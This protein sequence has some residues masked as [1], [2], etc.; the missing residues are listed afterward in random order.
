MKQAPGSIKKHLS[1][2]CTKLSSNYSH[3]LK[4]SA[5]S[6]RMMKKSSTIELMVADMND[7]V[8]EVHSALRSL[9]PAA[10]NQ[11]SGEERKQLIS[12]TETVHLMEVL[13]LIS[14]SSILIDISVRI[15]EIVDAIEDLAEL[16]VL[17]LIIMSSLER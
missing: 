3:V 9:Q 17:Q 2:V 11:S 4:Q 16:A 14:V 6:L 1:D 8:E 5:N 10:T 12:T 15:E 13:P 7:A